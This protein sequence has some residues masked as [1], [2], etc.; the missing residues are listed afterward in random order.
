MCGRHIY[1]KCAINHLTQYG[2][3]YFN[4]LIL[5]IIGDIEFR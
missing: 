1:R 4:M 2:E 5:Q 3:S